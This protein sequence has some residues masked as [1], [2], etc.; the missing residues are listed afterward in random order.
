MSQPENRR[1]RRGWWNKREKATLSYS[2][3]QVRSTGSN[4]DLKTE[5]GGHG[6]LKVL[7]IPN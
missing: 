2:D 1:R 7:D 6:C 4:P 5:E 3:V